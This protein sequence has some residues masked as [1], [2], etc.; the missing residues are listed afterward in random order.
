MQPIR[1]DPFPQ[2]VAMSN[3]LNRTPN[4]PY[5]PLTYKDGVLVGDRSEGRDREAQEGRDQR[6]VIARHGFPS[7]RPRARA[8]AA[9]SRQG[10]FVSGSR[11]HG[12]RVD[13]RRLRV[14][15]VPRSARQEGI[16]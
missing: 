2:L 12:R 4:D 5:T 3:R 6:R 16:A 10:F 13:D 15:P 14:E 1:W 11:A 9:D 8:L 7:P